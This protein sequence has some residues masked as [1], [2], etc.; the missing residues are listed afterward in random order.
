MNSALYIICALQM[1]LRHKVVQLSV[2]ARLS[3]PAVFF[4]HAGADEMRDMGIAFR[5]HWLQNTT[6]DILSS[7]HVHATAVSPVLQA[8]MAQNLTALFL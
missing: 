4:G 7:V 3:L 1:I 2:A 5:Q 8:F 6:Q